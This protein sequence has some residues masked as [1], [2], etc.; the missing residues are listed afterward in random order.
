MSRVLGRISAIFVVAWRRLWANRWLS[1]AE[2]SGFVA[3]VTLALAVPLYADAVYHRI[4]T[5][6]LGLT[7]PSGTRLP[8]FAFMFRYILYSGRPVALADIQPAD[9]Y[10]ST[11]LPDALA[12]PRT[13]LVRYYQTTNLRLYSA[14]QEGD[15][16]GQDPLLR[17]PLTSISHFAEHIVVNEGRLPVAAAQ[18][19]TTEPAN[20]DTLNPVEVLVSQTLAD[21][22][23]L[24]IGERLIAVTGQS[25]YNAVRVPVV[26]VGTWAPQDA[27]EVY[28]FYRPG[29]MDDMLM[30][31]EA[32]FTQQVAPHLQ[33]ELAEVLWYANFDGS[34]V[35]VWDV[36]RLVDRIESISKQA[37]AETLNLNISASPLNRLQS[38]QRDSQALMLRLYAL[39]IPLFVLAFAFV[40]LVASQ[41]GNS[42][43]NE[44][45]VLRSR[46]ASRWQVLGISFVQMSFVGAFAV[47]VATL[48]AALS[49]QFIGRTR[50]FF[51][52]TGT[53]WL[54]VAITPANLSF[55]I[56][57]AGLSIVIALLPM[58][59]TAQHTIISHK[60]ERA[61][62]LRPP[63]WQR[64]AL[65]VL[66]LIPAAYW[67][68][69][70]Q[71][72]GYV[73]IPGLST[74]VSVTTGAT[75]GVGVVDTTGTIDL[76]NNPSLLLVA[77]LSM[78]GLILVFIRLLPLLLRV[79]SHFLGL[80]PGTSTLLAFRQLARS[81]SYYATPVLLLSLTLSLAI[82]TQSLAATLDR[83]LDLE[84]YYAVGGDARLVGTGQD[85]RAQLAASTSQD[86][87]DQ[88]NFAPDRVSGRDQQQENTGPR[89]LFLPISD[90]TG[91]AGVRA[92]TRAGRYS[93]TP[94]YSA[95]NNEP[96]Q[97][98]G[99]DWSSY[100][101]VAFWRRDFADEPLGTLLNALGSTP[102]GVL[103]P[104]PTMEQHAL[105][106]GDVIPVMIALPDSNVQLTLKVV[107]GYKRWPTWDPGDQKTGPLFVGN[108]DYLFEH[109]GGQVP[110]D[111][112]L[113]LAAD[114]DA[115]AVET[116][117][118]TIDRSDWEY[119]N[120]RVQI[121][122]EQAQPERQG[123]FGIL[124]A[125][126]IT[127]VL[128]TVFGLFLY[129]A[130]SF[131]RRLIEFGVLRAIGFSTRQMAFTL[132]WELV[133][134]FAA[135]IGL[136]T[137]LGFAASQLY[138]PWLQGSATSATPAVPLIV[139]TDQFRLLL[140]YASIIGLSTM[141]LTLLLLTL[142]RL[143][144]FQAIKIGEAE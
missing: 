99:I 11:D 15:S 102:E 87:P 104:T 26:I 58:I 91:V 25:N 137:A 41:R 143:K 39:S 40:L 135:G 31:P 103:L 57:A 94:Q 75:T 144:L 30:M 71:R 24:S 10:I 68:Y 49:A 27:Y 33:K 119:R 79:I 88:V 28:W 126:V 113:A 43:R 118:H 107:G 1:F 80:L 116:Q 6:T 3:V 51:Q 84:T 140:I 122:Y 98:L 105:R 21:R 62:V 2:L 32:T 83:Q 89:W 9:Q 61:R 67:T 130:F 125:G 37:S 133:I 42:L 38:Y 5:T 90:Y 142:R 120:A 18:P 35:R 112:W 12:L 101:Q 76:F 132:A 16:A 82:F 121:E 106:V 93:L 115:T 114:A 117:L 123:L 96:G 81:P 131:R 34:G 127:A 63:W 86:N 8:A 65:D 53:E 139:I 73:D 85:N 7:G 97:F 136:G 141:A 134:L 17:I 111:V 66:L 48:P 52:F 128:L 100:A 45:A 74:N 29:L 124:S 44:T 23:G 78:L 54:P 22:A 72:Q 129:Y 60:Q 64:I 47:V 108:L 69:L 110:H 19:G 92:A 77:A 59:E 138:L 109:A 4:L 14:G 95:G 36:A 50:S 70:L 46:G 20:Q 56:V 55:G 13:D